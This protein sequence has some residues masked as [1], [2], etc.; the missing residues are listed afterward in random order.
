MFKDFIRKFFEK[1]L[2]SYQNASLDIRKKVRALFTINILILFFTIIMNIIL[3]SV[4][5]SMWTLILVSMLFLVQLISIFIL[6]KGKYKVASTLSLLGFGLLIIPI[7]AFSSYPEVVTK[8]NLFGVL[9]LGVLII[10]GLIGYHRFQTLMEII[11]AIIGSVAVVIISNLISGTEIVFNQ[12]VIR[13]ILV[14][15]III[16]FSGIFIMIFLSNTQEIIR[17]AEKE[18]DI[19]K[20]RFNKISNIITSSS[21]SIKIGEELTSSSEKTS[22][23]IND[24]DELLKRIQNEIVSLN[25]KVSNSSEQNKDAVK[26]TDE[27]KKFIENLNDTIKESSDS[28]GSMSKSIN[29]ISHLTE[30]KKKDIDLLI[31][32]ADEGE[33]EVLRSIEAINEVSHSANDILEVIKVIV[34]V[35]EQ[36]NMLAMNAAIEAA[37]AGDSGKGFAVVADEIRKLAEQTSQNTKIITQTL[38]KNTDNIKTATAIS[39]KAGEFFKEITIQ[40]KGVATS[41]NE[42]IVSMG[43]LVSGNDDILTYVSDVIEKSKKTSETVGKVENT[44]KQGNKVVNDVVVLSKDVLVQIEEI[45][46]GFD[47]IIDESKTVSDIGEK[48]I[49][50]IKEIYDDIDKIVADNDND[51][52]FQKDISLYEQ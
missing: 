15:G 11:L 49:Q 37:H 19:N 33:K 23:A 41:M 38:K 7:A 20:A 47:L 6:R 24:I 51:S 9:A 50:M 14:S 52:E 5:G 29:T 26:S 4:K 30:S 36:T 22:N 8:I 17:L 31:Q 40:I 2:A 46:N 3:S 48:N 27:L 32:K 12:L 18:A 10:T 25:D 13:A 43:K 28:I 35:A 1:N 34:N 21:E 44:I 16:I 45:I 39:N 42:V